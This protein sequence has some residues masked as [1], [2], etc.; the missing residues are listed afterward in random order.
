MLPLG[1]ISGPFTLDPLILLLLALALDAVLGEIPL[2]FRFVPHPVKVIGGIIAGAEAKLNRP[3]RSQRDRALR[4]ILLVA[5]MVA[6]AAAVGIGVSR[7]SL[8][9][10]RLWLVELFLTFTLLAQRSLFDHVRA[11]AEGLAKGLGAGRQAVAM[12][13]GRDPN[14]LDEHGVARAAIE[15]CAENFSDAVVAPV[16]WAVLFGFPGLL[17]YKT[18]NTLDSMIGHRSERYRAFG[19]AAARLDDVMNLAPARLA[20][21][22]IAL[23]AAFVPSGH[24]FKAVRTMLRDARHHRSPNSGWPEAAMAGALGLSRGGPRRYPGE[25]VKEKWIGDGRARATVKDVHRSL[26]VLALAC[27]LNALAVLGV[28]LLQRAA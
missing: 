17:V 16:F 6:G 2:V 7:L 3:H 26:S 4:G 21:L 14:S 5:A 24:P 25:I 1:H 13:V 23:A 18:V 22:L 12:I 9:M 27:V 15:S 8:A 19:W 20:G 11:V 28:F 10:P